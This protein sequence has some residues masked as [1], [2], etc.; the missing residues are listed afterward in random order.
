M[1]GTGDR[2]GWDW[3]RRTGNGETNRLKAS[4]ST[5]PPTKL[6]A[7]LVAG[8]ILSSRISGFVRLWVFNGYFGFSAEADAFNQA[9]RIPNLLQNLFGEG[10]LSAS[11]I[12]VY[13]ALV[14]SGDRRQADRVAGAVASILA[15]LVAVLVL[16]GVL[17]SPLLVTLIAPGFTGAKRELTVQI[18]RVLFPGAGLL[19][20]GRAHV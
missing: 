20:I 2:A 7:A 8:G 11:F 12:P 3:D 17:A 14:S 9:F 5:A 6:S 4:T 13:S 18:V 1:K 16:L 19:E 15:L 10:A